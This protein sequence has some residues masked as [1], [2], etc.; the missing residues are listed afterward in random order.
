MLVKKPVKLFSV[1]P[2]NFKDAT[3]IHH[4]GMWYA[5][6]SVE[7]EDSANVHV[8]NN[9]EDTQ[10]A[11]KL[12]AVALPLGHIL[13]KDHPNATKYCVITNWWKH[14]ME[15][16]WYRLPTLDAT[17]YGGKQAVPPVP[18][19]TAAAVV[20][21][22]CDNVCKESQIAF[23]FEAVRHNPNKPRKEHQVGTLL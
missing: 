2:V 5:D 21:Q 6:I 9:F 10:A 22:G 14:R 13:G 18:P 3:G 12:A 20:M 17:L 16:G 15:D 7:P 11:A 1:R 19:V 23:P 4:H 8:A